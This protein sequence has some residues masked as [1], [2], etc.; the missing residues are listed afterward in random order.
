MKLGIRKSKFCISAAAREKKLLCEATLDAPIT[1][2][3]AAANGVVYV[4]THKTLY[5]LAKL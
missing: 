4:A 2:T 5:A 1:A 3:L